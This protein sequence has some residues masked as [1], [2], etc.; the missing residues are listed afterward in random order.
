MPTA[1]QFYYTTWIIIV[2][3]CLIIIAYGLTKWNIKPKYL[4]YLT[5]YAFASMITEV[6]N[7]LIFY[8]LITKPAIN[9]I[10]IFTIFEFYIFAIIIYNTLSLAITKNT[11]IIISLIYAI[12]NV[13]I[14]SE[15]ASYWRLNSQQI[16]ADNVCVIFLCTLYYVEI[17]KLPPRLNLLSDPHYWLIN[18][19]L[20]YF[21]GSSPLYAF[22]EFFVSSKDKNYLSGLF[23]INSILFIV[24]LSFI[25]KAIKCR[26]MIT[27]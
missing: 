10:S 22:S 16:L 18:G 20:L 2:M 27:Q 21:A 7:L 26:R 9:I 6:S 3:M 23:L 24:M 5:I 12:I 14:F 4:N 19:A 8:K 17:F 1:F 11:V 25:L 15:K 13:I